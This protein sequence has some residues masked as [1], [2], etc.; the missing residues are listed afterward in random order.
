MFLKL[1]VSANSPNARLVAVVLHEKK[2]LFEVIELDF[3]KDLKSPKYLKLQP[4]GQEPTIDDDG[5]ILYESRAIAHYIASKYSNQGTPLL[6]TELKANALFHQAASVSI[7]HFST[8]AEKIVSELYYKPVFLKKPTNQ[9]V[10]DNS[11][12]ELGLKLDIYDQILGKQKYIAG[13]E[14]TLADFYHIPYGETLA[15]AGSNIMETRPNVA[16]WFKEITARPSWQAVKGT[17]EA[18]KT[19]SWSQ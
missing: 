7:S 1:Y 11:L 12:K 19:S 8:H 2:V 18:E 17:I 15:V 16:K 9:E 10:V 3:D 13:D 5:F 4:F 6:P 14:I